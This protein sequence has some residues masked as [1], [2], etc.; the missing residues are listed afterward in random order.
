VL[1]TV[2]DAATL[3]AFRDIDVY[4]AP[5]GTKTLPECQLT[6]AGLLTCG[7]RK[8]KVGMVPERAHNF[9][10]Q[11]IKAKRRQYGLRHHIAS[12]IHSAVGH[13]VPKLATEL[14]AVNSVWERAMVVVLILRVR[15]ASDLIFVG[16]AETNVEALMGG[17]NVRNQYDEYMDHIVSVLTG[18]VPASQALLLGHHPFRYKD[19]PIPMD[20]SGVVY[21][22]VSQKDGRSMY[23]GNSRNMVQRLGQ[24]NA[25]IGSLESAPREKRPWGLYAYITGFA[26]NRGLMEAVEGHWQRSVKFLKPVNAREAVLIIQRILTRD[27][28][29]SHFIVVVADDK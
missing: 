19:I 25:G 20:R 17:L 11:G 27:Y 8:S 14:G 3:S 29:E 6:E 23:I 9:W 13:T 21:I 4:V 10:K 26:G 7:F 12:T 1:L 15:K 24:H 2:S 16:D 5:A 28:L 18:E 22:L